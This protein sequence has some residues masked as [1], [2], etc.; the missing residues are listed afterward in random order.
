MEYKNKDRWSR[1]REWSIR[2]RI[3]EVDGE[4]GV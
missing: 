2:I 1:C 4:K 3:G